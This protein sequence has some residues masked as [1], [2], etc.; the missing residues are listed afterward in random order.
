M[1]LAEI[2]VIVTIIVLIVI[3][4][5]FIKKNCHGN[6]DKKERYENVGI[7]DDSYEKQQQEEDA[8]ACQNANY[9]VG[10][11]PD[12]S[13]V[14]GNRNT[15]LRNS[16]TLDKLKQYEIVDNIR[17]NTSRQKNPRVITPDYER[18]LV[19]KA[20]L[21]YFMNNQYHPDYKDVLTSIED[22]VPA[23]KQI[24]NIANIPLLDYTEPPASE[25]T[26]MMYDFIKTFNE[27]SQK[28]ANQAATRSLESGWLNAGWNDK[29]VDPTHTQSGWDKVQE[30]LGLKPN[31]YTNPAPYGPMEL[32]AIKRVQK[33]ETDDEIKYQILAV[34]HKINVQD[35]IMLEI[36]LIFDKRVERDEANFLSQN[37]K[38]VGNGIFKPANDNLQ[39]VVENIQII[40][41]LTTAQTPMLSEDYGIKYAEYDKLEFQNMTDPRYIQSVLMDRYKKRNNDLNKRNATLDDEGRE[42]HESM[43][44]PWDYPNLRLTQT[45]FDD[46]NC[47]R[48]FS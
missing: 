25:V 22:L 8:I 26:A 19:K 29:L 42:F 33:F 6:N 23:R 41:Y 32:I 18:V 4:I 45:I 12:V 30:S 38:Y 20:E 39:M 48:T 10:Y 24:F 2:I 47:V 1:K 21:P 36:S 28:N 40:G 44:N 9:T 31:L 16:S 17:T 5:I 14:E 11:G 15:A 46:M 27:I 3:I 37:I 43:A 7:F 35:Q 34:L 13:V